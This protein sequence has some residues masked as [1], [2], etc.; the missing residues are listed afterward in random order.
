[1][2][3]LD[4]ATIDQNEFVQQYTFWKN[5]DRNAMTRMAMM[6]VCC[7]CVKRFGSPSGHQSLSGDKYLCE[8]CMTKV[9]EKINSSK[10][11]M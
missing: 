10:N 4:I 3:G 7:N 6:V 5:A 11:D 1:M 2:S 9:F 8:E